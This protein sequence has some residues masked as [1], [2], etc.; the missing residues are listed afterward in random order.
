MLL[1][2]VCIFF[3][4]PSP[5]GYAP[6]FFGGVGFPEPGTKERKVLDEIGGKNGATAYQVALNWILR[7]EGVITIPKAKNINHIKSNLKAL[8]LTLSKEDQQLIDS[9][10]PKT[11]EGLSLIKY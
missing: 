9:F 7:H 2:D 1:R 3:S 10:F 4:K 8:E 11:N 5:F 6:Q